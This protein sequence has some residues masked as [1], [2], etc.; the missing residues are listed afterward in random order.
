[1]KL[2][3]IV[4]TVGPSVS[5]K[6]IIKSLIEEGVNLFRFNF[7]HGTVEEHMEKIGWIRSLRA[8]G[9]NAGIFVDLGGPK[10]RLGVFEKDG[11]VF[12]EPGQF[13]TLTLKEIVGNK[14]IAHAPLA[15]V[16]HNLKPHDTILLA[17]GTVEL[18][19]VEVKEDEIITVV[20]IGGEIS[21][22]KGINIPNR[23]Q[24]IS[25]ITEKDISDLEAGISAGVKM[26]ALSF[27]G[28]PDDIVKARKLAESMGSDIFVISKI[29]RAEA[30][31]NFDRILELSDAIM[32][33]RGDLAVE[34]PYYKVPIVQ[35]ELIAK[36][37]EK[38]RPVIT[39]THMLRSILYSPVP[40]RSEISDIANAVLDG[41]SALMLSEETAI[42][43]DP[44]HSVRVMKSIIN[45]VE[46][47]VFRNN[48]LR[49]RQCK[50]EDVEMKIAESAVNLALSLRAKLIITPT[51]SGATALRVASLLPPVPI[52]APCYEDDVFEFLN[53]A[54]GVYSIRVQEMR[55][56]DEIMKFV[57]EFVKNKGLAS[58][59]DTVVITA[60]YPLGIPGT[61]NMVR[62][63]KI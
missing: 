46:G 4:A 49:H 62:V 48:I 3:K 38:G 27:V 44:V 12:L 13:F 5:S 39:A 60:G 9:Y 16:I 42:A 61:T 29:E 35:K 33:A 34:I 7:S 28:S 58:P 20:R 24:N 21:S 55:D 11:R 37:I 52:I 54:Y 45:E 25:C 17:D 47:Y 15:N 14:N 53:I 32:V 26:F 59:G 57:R 56:F 2:T 63:E 1:M 10:F 43:K 18:E 41:S 40:S 50:L 8:E 31:D 36:A 22:H 51:A 30:L 19:V 23:M 6:E